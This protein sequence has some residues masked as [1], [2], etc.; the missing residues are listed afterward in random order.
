MLRVALIILIGISLFAQSFDVFA[1]IPS[2]QR[3]KSVIKRVK[4]ELKNALSKKSLKWGA[5][6]FIRIIKEPKEL[7]LWVKGKDES[8]LFRTYS[9]CRFSGKPGPKLKRGDR[10]SPEGFYFAIPRQ[11]NPWSNYHL[12]INVGYP[13]QYDRS[14]N[15]TG[16]A[17]MIHGACASVGCYAMMDEKMEE[18]YALADAALRNGQRFFR[19]HI[20][21]FRMTQENMEKNKYRKEGFFRKIISS[22]FS[23]FKSADEKK[24]IARNRYSEWFEFWRNLKEGYDIFEKERTPP[25]VRVKNGMYV[26]SE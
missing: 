19:I 8:V 21:P 23:L 20:F 14:H 7:E 18:I 22:F 10:Q 6:I 9:I 24:K 4:P 12:A 13:N 26:F 11:L 25:N 3:S 16:S 5:P 2:S 17:I 15:R 1:Q